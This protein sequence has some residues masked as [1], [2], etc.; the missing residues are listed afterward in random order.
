MTRPR[1]ELVS[2]HDTPYY[3][4]VSRC[5]RRA[6]LCGI[7]Q[8]TGNNYKHR[9]QWIEN[10]IRLLSSIFAVNICAYAVMSNHIHLTLQLCPDEAEAW[11][12]DDILKRWTSLFK[13]PCLVQQWQ[14]GEQLQSAEW[15]TVQSCAAVYQQR[16][17]SLSWFMKCLNEPIARQANQEDG[18][19]G[20]FW[21][22]RFKSQALLTEEAL[23]SCMTYVDLNP[24]R[25][26]IARTPET[27]E[28]TS[29]K[30][31]ITPSFNLL[32]AIQQQCHQ[33]VLNHF[34]LPLKPLVQ[35]EGG[36]HCREQQGVLFGFSDYL[37]LVDY[38]GKIVRKDKRG[39]IPFQ[40]PPILQRLG[41]DSAHWVNN[42]MYFEKNY[43]TTFSRRKQSVSKSA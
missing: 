43:Y 41:I 30:E 10:R 18:C 35:F 21:E 17:C 29:I 25:A 31:R 13:G 23:L 9:R 15:E 24:V 1:K 26:K 3:H 40:L 12:V 22:A 7:D 2:I 42:A 32:E 28:Y 34:D 11:S 39:A 37:E 20:H 38:T 16:L 6:F 8:T 27:S 36:I 19:T 5:V 33:G 4:V 14:R